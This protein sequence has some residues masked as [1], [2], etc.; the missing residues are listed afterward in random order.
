M[1]REHAWQIIADQRQALADLLAGLSADEWEHASLCDGWRVRDV[2]AH[3]A[4]GA[5]PPGL[6]S[7][8]VAAGRARGSFHRLNHDIAV[9]HAGRPTAELVAELRRDAGARKVPIV[10]NYRNIFF[11][12]LVHAQDIAIQLGRSLPMPD[13]AA[14]DAASIVWALGWPFNARRRLGAL[15][16]T[17]SNVDWTVGE[18]AEV[19]GPIDALLLLLT[20]RDQAALPR[21]TGAGAVALRG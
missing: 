4:L 21:L 8:A 12:V 19:Q 5:K 15:R 10:S 1:D 18:G 11:D 16:L 20:G 14:R 17:A 13:D 3:V 9:R 6:G 7:I 2:A